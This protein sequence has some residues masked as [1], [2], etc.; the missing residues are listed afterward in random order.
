M[1]VKSLY[2]YFL[3]LFVSMNAI[4]GQD[5]IPNQILRVDEQEVMEHLTKRLRFGGGTPE[6]YLQVSRYHI[7]LGTV[8][9]FKTAQ[10][11]LEEAILKYDQNLPLILYYAD[12]LYSHE[13]ES[14]AIEQYEDV[15]DID[16]ECWPAWYRLGE[17]YRHKMVRYRHEITS[18]GWSFQEY[19]AEYFE[20]ADDAFKKCLDNNFGGDSLIVSIF[21]LYYDSN[22]LIPAA[23]LLDSY[24]K[25]QNRNADLYELGGLVNVRLKIYDMADAYYKRAFAL[26]SEEQKDPYY[27]SKNYLNARTQYLTTIQ[28]IFLEDPLLITEYNERE[29]EHFAR[30]TYAQKN[31]SIRFSEAVGWQSDQGKVIIR[32]GFPLDQVVIRGEIEGALIDEAWKP[33]WNYREQQKFNDYGYWQKRSATIDEGGGRIRDTKNPIYWDLLTW[34]YPDFQISFDD[35]FNNGQFQFAEKNEFAGRSKSRS[36]KSHA[37]FAE[38]LFNTK[39]EIYMLETHGGEIEAIYEL[40]NNQLKQNKVQFNFNYSFKPSEISKIKIPWQF[41]LYRSRADTDI[42]RK[43]SEWT[44]S[45]ADNDFWQKDTIWL[46]QKQYE[47]YSGIYNWIFE[48]FN[49]DTQEFFRLQFSDTINEFNPRKLT[50]GDI[51][52]SYYNSEGSA[53]L[54]S[55]SEIP[56][57]SHSFHHSEHMVISFDMEGLDTLDQENELEIQYTIAPVGEPESIWETL[58]SIF[59]ADEEVDLGVSVTNNY[60]VTNRYHRVKQMLNIR[61]LSPSE[62][63]LH[64]SVREI[65]SQDERQR[66]VR[67]RVK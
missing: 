9:G 12:I 52:L 55:L 41:A 11:L 22:N 1:R 44:S 32:Y 51:Q 59:V 31:F 47:A 45:N 37:F 38:N 36:E 26:M 62:Y 30:V 35:E 64:V 17:V 15:I 34:Y 16:E 40:V 20:L 13:F 14:E 28:N 46:G 56:N 67:F 29:L 39:P 53:N 3:L 60:P 21:W 2:I 19:A 61:N 43:F 58:G 63:I 65:F 8:N 54:A 42:Y 4:L 6:E 23:T 10:K 24:F 66:Q 50:M 48:G 57:A 33:E 49:G 27:I 18:K 5:S 7:S 25:Y